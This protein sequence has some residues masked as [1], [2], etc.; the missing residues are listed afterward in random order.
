MTISAAFRSHPAIFL[1]GCLLSFLFIGFAMTILGLAVG[2]KPERIGQAMVGVMIFAVPLG[3][4]TCVRYFVEQR[5]KSLLST[6][7]QRKIVFLVP[8]GI[9]FLFISYATGDK[10]WVYMMSDPLFTFRYM[11]SCYRWTVLIAYLGIV[12]IVSGIVFSI[13]YEQTVGALKQWVNG[14]KKP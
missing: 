13:F 6:S 9:F 2:L 8:F 4:V 7:S 11:D 10:N 5:G 12:S 3:G 1:V 14:S